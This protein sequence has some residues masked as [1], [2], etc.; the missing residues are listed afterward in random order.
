MTRMR[1]DSIKD[2]GVPFYKVVLTGGPCGGKTT[3]LERV[4]SYLRERGFEVFSCPEAFTILATNGFS[5]DYFATQ[6]M[7]IVAQN[8]ILNWQKSMEDGME[9]ILRARGLPAVLLCDRGIQDGA[10]YM[11]LDDW[12][13]FLQ[14]RGLNVTNVREGRYNA[15]FHMVTAAEGAQDFY[16]LDNNDARTETLE[17][18]R[19][20]DKKTQRAWVG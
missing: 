3:A 14:S 11:P 20:M 8:T 16:T 5:L 13:K 4:S 10:A 9:A 17:E 6:G 15:V 12:N 18:A 7:D 1:S 2:N 19:E